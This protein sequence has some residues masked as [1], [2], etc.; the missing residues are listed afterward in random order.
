[1]NLWRLLIISLFSFFILPSFAQK[2]QFQSRVITIDSLPLQAIITLKKTDSS[3]LTKLITDSTGHFSYPHI[4]D[5]H[6]LLQVEALGYLSSIIPFEVKEHN[7][8]MPKIISLAVSP[9]DLDAV[10]VVSK[11]AAVVIKQDTLEYSSSSVKLGADA[12]TED[13]FQKLP[14]IAVFLFDHIFRHTFKHHFT[15]ISNKPG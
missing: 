2:K 10:V 9:N 6:Y 5:G 7:Y 11:K 4:N 8:T 3:V 13:I 12:T 14:G 15:R 1:M